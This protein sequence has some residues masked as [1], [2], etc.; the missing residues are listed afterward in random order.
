M[1]SRLRI[2]LLL[3]LAIG[4]LV[5]GCGSDDDRDTLTVMT[6][7]V[8]FGADTSGVFAQ[9]VAGI[10]PRQL[11]SDTG[12]AFDAME[13][14]DFPL[15]ATAIAESIAAHEPQFVGLQEMVVI[16]QD[17]SNFAMDPMPDAET[18]VMDFRKVM[19]HALEAQGMNYEIAAQVKNRDNELPMC[20]VELSTCLSDPTMIQDGRLTMFDVLLVRDDVEVSEPLQR[21]Y[22][23]FIGPPIV[24]LTVRRGYVAIDATVANRTY[25]VVST[26]LETFNPQDPQVRDAQTAELIGVLE[27]EDL[28]II[29]LGDFNSSPDIESGVDNQDTY[30][31]VTEAGFIDMWKGGPGTGLTCCQGT[32]LTQENELSKRIDFVFV[33]NSPV[34]GTASIDTHVDDAFVVGDQ[35]ADRVDRG[36]GVL[37]WPSDHA[38]VGAVLYIK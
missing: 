28:P 23:A 10:G 22:S 18:E 37:L 11:L 8:Y 7:N 9:L 24:P 15:R 13:E 29:L 19:M 12:K 31:A 33:R 32:D 1:R 4:L 36:D 30:L 2:V 17:P 16:R 21:N 25:R 3:C 20:R 34:S 27:R 5:I 6:Y 35:H 14:T 38:G 26:H